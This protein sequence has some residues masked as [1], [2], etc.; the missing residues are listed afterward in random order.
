MVNDKCINVDSSG[1][2]E[3][4]GDTMALSVGTPE[5]LNSIGLLKE[6][7]K[8]DGEWWINLK[9]ISTKKNN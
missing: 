8:D 9:N 1:F 7:K 4:V 6:L 2:H 3:A 5:H